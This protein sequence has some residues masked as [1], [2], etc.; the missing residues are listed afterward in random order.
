MGIPNTPI[1]KEQSTKKPRNYTPYG[2]LLPSV[3]TIL[4]V[5][6]FP[7]IM[8]VYISLNQLNL[9]TD[10]GKF[11]FKGV[12]NF[13]TLCTKESNEGDIYNS[14]EIAKLIIYYSG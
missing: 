8:A 13:I 1:Q 5:I 4:V 2:F 12:E 14:C 10:A 9:V 7:F 3:I 11:F 6:L